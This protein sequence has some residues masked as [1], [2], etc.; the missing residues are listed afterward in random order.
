MIVKLSRT[1][2]WTESQCA[3]R[4]KQSKST[5]DDALANEPYALA[6]GI[7]PQ[8]VAPQEAGNIDLLGIRA[9]CAVAKALGLDFNPYHLGID[10]GADLFAGDVSIDVKARFQRQKHIVPHTG[11]VPR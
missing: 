10:N 3:S 8:R 2:G 11:K 6:S 7:E 5:K 1:Q 9:E 4:C